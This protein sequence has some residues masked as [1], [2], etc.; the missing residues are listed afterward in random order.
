[1]PGAVEQG[2][3]VNDNKFFCHCFGLEKKAT[4]GIEPAYRSF[5]DSRLTTW[6]RGR[7]LNLSK[8]A[9]FGNLSDTKTRKAAPPQ[10]LIHKTVKIFSLTVFYFYIINFR[11]FAGFAL[12]RQ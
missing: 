5:A 11:A 8:K 12:L 2:I 7:F 4:A 6:L 10:K 3:A 9:A 1:M